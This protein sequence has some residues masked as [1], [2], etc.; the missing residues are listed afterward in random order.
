MPRKTRLQLVNE[1]PATDEEA[2]RLAGAALDEAEALERPLAPPEDIL[3]ALRSQLAQTT[4]VANAAIEQAN[5]ERVRADAVAQDLDHAKADTIKIRQTAVQEVSRARQDAAE[6]IAATQRQAQIAER[7]AAA[8]GMVRN[9]IGS[10]GGLLSFV[11]DRAPVLG[12]LLGAYL[13]ARNILAQPDT[14][15]LCLLAIYGGI[16]IAPAVWLAVRKG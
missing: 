14:Y 16:T 15:Q 11:I 8:A 6:T 4:E 10:I 13:L 3:A 12:S 1:R 5:Q 2:S 7:T 9:L